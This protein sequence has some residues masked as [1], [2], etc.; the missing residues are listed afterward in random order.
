MLE[1]VERLRGAYRSARAP[2]GD[3]EVALEADAL[4]ASLDP[5]RTLGV[6]RAFSIYFLLVNAAEQHHRVRR[7]RMRDAEREEEQRYQPESIAAAI[8]A[9]TARRD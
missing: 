3:P 5:R 9:L 1:L 4:V 6:I 7:R 8:A 2:D